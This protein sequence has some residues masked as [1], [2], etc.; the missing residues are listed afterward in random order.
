[1]MNWHYMECMQATILYYTIHIAAMK[2]ICI[3]LLTTYYVMIYLNARGQEWLHPIGMQVI[4]LIYGD[5]V[6]KTGATTGNFDCVHDA[7][8]LDFYLHFCSC[9]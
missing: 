9:A 4:M 8:E 7:V 5:S 1:M 3:N 6:N 2:R